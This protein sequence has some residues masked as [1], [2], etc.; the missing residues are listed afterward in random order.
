MAAVSDIL[1]RKGSQV[2]TIGKAA[3]ALEAAEVMNVHKI[4]AV[5]VIDDGK[6]IG[7]F[8]ERDVL[9]RIVA[10]RKDP[11]T[12]KVSE[13]MTPDP[14]CCDLAT[15]IDEARTVMKDRRIRHLPVV[16][17]DRKLL[18]M[19]SIGDL[20]AHLANSQEQTIYQMQEYLYGR[21]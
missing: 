11:E 1:A 21:M 17:P 8:T 18:G 3:S 2:W 12:A 4:G 15:S 19:I 5:V 6:V 13:V 7:I 16:D 20:N 14:L 10:S 9:Q